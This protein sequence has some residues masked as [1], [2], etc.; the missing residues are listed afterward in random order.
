MKDLS[1]LAFDEGSFS[2]LVDDLPI[3]V[4]FE[5]CI[6]AAFDFSSKIN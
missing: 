1:I 6:F 5:G 3:G 2:N 4:D